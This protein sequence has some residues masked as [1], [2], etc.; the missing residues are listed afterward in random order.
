MRSIMLIGVVLLVVVAVNLALIWPNRERTELKHAAECVAHIGIVGRAV[1][2]YEQ[3]HQERP[4]DLR[5]LV[6]LGY[7]DSAEVLRCPA[8]SPGNVSYVLQTSNTDDQEGRSALL[9]EN[10]ARHFGNRHSVVY[11]DGSSDLVFAEE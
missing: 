11:T 3:E 1:L 5:R 10:V 4:A 9:V 2:A 8:D 7:V 6:Q